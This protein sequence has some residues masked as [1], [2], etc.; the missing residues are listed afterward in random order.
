MGKC[1]QNEYAII[2]V[3]LKFTYLKRKHGDEIK[4]IIKT[5]SGNQCIYTPSDSKLIK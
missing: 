5:N 2:K 4:G 3:K 1:D